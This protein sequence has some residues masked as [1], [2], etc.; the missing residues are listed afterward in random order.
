MSTRQTIIEVEGMTCSSC[1]RHVEAALREFEGIS[2]V[3][4]D[5]HQGKV[6]VDH[7]P[8]SAPVDAMIAALGEAGYES[9]PPSP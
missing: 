7:D 1:V 2:A 4:V 9:R 8:S 5:R 3:K 6:I